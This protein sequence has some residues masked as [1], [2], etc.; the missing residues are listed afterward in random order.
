MKKSLLI[1][2]VINLVYGF[3]YYQKKVKVE[4]PLEDYYPLLKEASDKLKASYVDEEMV[5]NDRLS[6][7]A[8]KGML[9]NLD[10]YSNYY[11]P[12]QNKAQSEDLEGR[13]A[14]VGVLFRVQDEGVFIRRVYKDSPAEKA[15]ML[16]GD[17][18]V[19]ADGKDL[20]GLNSSSVVKSLKGEP[21]TIVKVSV[22]RGEENLSLD[23][24][25]GYVSVPTINM[26]EIVSDQIG[27]IYI[28]QFGGG[29][30]AEFDK[31]FKEL[32]DKGMKALIIDLRFN[33]GGY[34]SA[35]V[36]I[37]SVFLDYGS[38]VVYKEGRGAERE[39][40]FDTTKEFRNDIPVVL[41][42]NSE[43]ASASEVTAACL[44]DH[45]S[46]L[47]VG[48]KT[49]GKGSVQVIS[50]MSNG[51]SLRFTVAKYFS[52]GGYVIHGKGLDPDVE[53]ELS[54][55]ELSDLRKNIANYGTI[56]SEIPGDKQ[57]EQA[58]QLLLEAL[59]SGR[60]KAPFFKDFDSE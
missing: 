22:L 11:T 60:V 23:I 39:D 57:F 47:L 37:C 27:Y 59:E 14:G 54:A 31:S 26:A 51:G 16:A 36:D 3:Y 38:L 50:P 25:R 43:S 9:K 5:K 56:E 12:N 10:R 46:A 32:F 8:L 24:K 19:E 42:V 58:K 44:R 1:L 49:Y 35:A 45:K 52:P 21:G 4:R 15:G 13:F 28:S 41:L 17:L 33:G 7:G 53:V 20:L 30:T 29:T 2:A 34:L 55:V 18:I 40:L 48:E 6:T